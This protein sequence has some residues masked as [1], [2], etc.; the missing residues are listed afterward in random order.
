MAFEHKENNVLSE[1]KHDYFEPLI[2][3]N[4]QPLE[5]VARY[6]DPQ[7]Q[8]AKNHSYLF[9]HFEHKYYKS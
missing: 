1:T 3:V 4:F 6:R 5:V 9:N 7:L 2:Y 8:V